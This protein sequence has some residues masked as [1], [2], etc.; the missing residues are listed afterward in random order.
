MAEGKKAAISEILEDPKAGRLD[1]FHARE[2]AYSISGEMAILEKLDR[3]GAAALQEFARAGRARA[4]GPDRGRRA[5]DPAEIRGGCGGAGAGERRR[6]RRLF[7]GP[8]PPGDEGLRRRGQEFPPGRAGRAG[9]VRLRHGGGGGAARR[10]QPRRGAGENPRLPEDPRCPGGTPLPEGALLRGGRRLRVG[11][12]GV[13]ARRGTRSAARRRA[14]PIGL[15]ERPARQRRPGAGLLREGR[16]DPPAPH[17]RADEPGDSLRGPGRL[18]AR[19]C[20]PS[21]AWRPAT[22]AS[23]ARGCTPP[24][25]RRA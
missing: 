19:R 16:G 7:P 21:P 11:D 8:V 6:G 5:V 9:R 17:E 10:G 25:P 2:L 4:V 1:F 24:T 23:R 3:R 12:G 22:R 13:R 18:R 20:A 14:V 15:L